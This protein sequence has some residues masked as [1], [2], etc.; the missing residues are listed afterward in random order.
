[1]EGSGGETFCKRGL[2]VVRDTSQHRCSGMVGCTDGSVCSNDLSPVSPVATT[3]DVI[4]TPHHVP[5]HWQQ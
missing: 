4:M 1:M 2:K 5:L 3:D